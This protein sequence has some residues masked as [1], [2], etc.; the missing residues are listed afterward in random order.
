MSTLRDERKGFTLMEVLVV[1]AILA[2]LIALLLPAGQS[3][4]EAAARAQSMNNLRQIGLAT[5]GYAGVNRNYLP[6]INGFNHAARRYE[7]SLFVGL[8]P[9]IEEGNIYQR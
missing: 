4:R 5:H 9:Y 3:V 2:L 6:N 1:I 8:L 7:F